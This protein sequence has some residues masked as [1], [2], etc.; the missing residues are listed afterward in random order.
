MVAYCELGS[1]LIERGEPDSAR[2][3]LQ[4]VAARRPEG[5]D[6]WNRL[7][8][9]YFQLGEL[10][11]AQA[12]W[13]TSLTFG[14]SYAAYSNLG[15]VHFFAS[16]WSEAAEMFEHALAIETDDYQLWFNLA[17]AYGQLPGRRPGADSAYRRSLALS[18]R[19]R[20]ANPRNAL[21]IIHM[22][23]C[24]AALDD[25]THALEF[26]LGA[27]KGQ[28]DNVQ[29]VV[30]AGMVYETL[31]HRD[32]A[33]ELMG[34]ALDLGFPLAYLEA[35]PQLH[36]LLRDPRLAKRGPGDQESETKE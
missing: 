19:E 20:A 29:V 32:P 22:A 18:E 12:M 28:P 31:G 33:V 21:L 6:A 34:R 30:R 1:L 27:L 10:A 16:R 36:E 13:D 8:A 15:S 11:R 23:E 3:V 2:T 26:A 4:S 14:P 7:G 24:Y 25:S 17:S 35:Q 9:L 5:Y